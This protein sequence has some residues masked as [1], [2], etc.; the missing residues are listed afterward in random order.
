M[1]ALS[2]EIPQ[3]QTSLDERLHWRTDLHREQ[4]ERGDGRLF[5]F[6]RRGFNLEVGH[7]EL[8][9]DAFDLDRDDL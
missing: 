6:R 1:D 3:P 4:E 9:V 2:R 5:F 7:L 8:A